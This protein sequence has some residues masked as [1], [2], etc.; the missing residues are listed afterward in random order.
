MLLLVNKS[1]KVFS[2]APCVCACV[3]VFTST[4]HAVGTA[5]VATLSHHVLNKVGQLHVERGPICFP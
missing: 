1:V 3:F 5:S 4:E 2:G